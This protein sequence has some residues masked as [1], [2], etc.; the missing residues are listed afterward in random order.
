M[1]LI[2]NNNVNQVLD[3]RVT[4]RGQKARMFKEELQER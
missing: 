4:I 3:V 1:I 2:K